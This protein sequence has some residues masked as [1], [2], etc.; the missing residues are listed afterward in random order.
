M[1]NKRLVE[2]KYGPVGF[3]TLQQLGAGGGTGEE[4][5]HWGAQP[6]APPLSCSRPSRRST[7]FS[8][9][10]SLA[11]TLTSSDLP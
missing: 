3:R 5:G 4:A 10:Q 6:A 7:G 11:L 1:P 9:G 8:L 2:G